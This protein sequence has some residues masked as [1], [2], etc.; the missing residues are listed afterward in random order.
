MIK[1][2]SKVKDKITGFT[3]VATQ[4]IQYLYGCERYG[5]EAKTGKD[6]KA[7]FEYFDAQRLEY[8]SKVVDA[9]VQET[10]GDFEHSPGR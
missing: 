1:L 9:V 2:G 6:G 8:V 4:R 3:G 5:V 10:G 7:P